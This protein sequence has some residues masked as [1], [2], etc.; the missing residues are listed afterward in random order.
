MQ[1]IKFVMSMSLAN[2]VRVQSTCL[3]SDISFVSVG[4]LGEI[5]L[6]VVTCVL[7]STC[8]YWRTAK[9]NV[10]RRM[11]EACYLVANAPAVETANSEFVRR[12][13]R[14]FNSSCF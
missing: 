2:V 1:H 3:L 4:I 6:S 7:C 9:N 8:L 14:G 11:S 12:A 10:K 13:L 5:S